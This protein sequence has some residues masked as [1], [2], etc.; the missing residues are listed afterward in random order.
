MQFDL[1]SAR[2]GVTLSDEL[3]GVKVEGRDGAIGKVDHVNYEGTCLIVTTGRLLG[4]KHAIPAWAV[5]RVD[6]D[7]SVA[8]DLTKA[9]VEGSPAYDDV[10]GFDDACET[11]VGEYYEDV[12]TTR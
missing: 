10:V 5:E 1:W 8:V 2:S 3:E 6:P 7:G 12:M 11:R 4:K 9:E